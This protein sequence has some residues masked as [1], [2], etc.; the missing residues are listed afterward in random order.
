MK[1][2]DDL[3]TPPAKRVRVLLMISSMRGGGSERQTLLLLRHLDRNR[4]EPHLYMVEA[5]GELLTQVPGDVVVHAYQPGKSASGVYFPGRILRDQIR[6]LESVLRSA[7]I[8]VIY[9]R[10]FHMTMIAAPAAKRLAIPRVSTLVSPPDRALP[11]VEKRFVW[12][13]KRRLA[14]AYHQS[15]A[16]VAVSQQ[17]ADA[18]VGYYGLPAHA[19][20][21]IANPVD[22]DA[23]T[24]QA[25]E[26]IRFEKREGR[27]TLV[28]VGRMTAEKGQRVLIEAIT[29]LESRDDLPALEVWLVGNGVLRAE[30]EALARKKVSRHQIQFVGHQDNAPAWITKA[31]ALV[32]PSLFEGMP[33]VVLEAM[34]IGV[35]VIATSAGGTVELQRDEPT[36]FMAEPGNASSLAQAIAAFCEQPKTRQAHVEAAKCLINTHHDVSRNVRE[37]ET[38]L[39]RAI[40]RSLL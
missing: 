30:L 38:T 14:K 29:E 37:I 31:D 11:M 15:A 8:D 36:M 3:A 10:T 12:L 39:V 32:L 6:H 23:V 2:H 19:Q 9:D 21:V 13:K 17:V 34:A 27:I 7:K 18:A 1:E 24:S 16:V 40:A 26:D 5:E 28:C 20:T 4:F 22:H 25:K 35:P 33:N